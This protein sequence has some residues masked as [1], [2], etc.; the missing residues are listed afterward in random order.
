MEYIQIAGKSEIWIGVSADR[1]SDGSYSTMT[2]VGEQIDDT[3]LAVQ[4]FYHD[5]PGDRHGGPQGPP[6]ERQILGQIVRG[7]FNLSRFDPEVRRELT[8]QNV[9]AT[10]GT[11]LDSEI[12][13]LLLR[14]RS[15]RVVI[16]P[17]RANPIGVGLDGAGDDYYAWNFPCVSINGAIECGQGTKFSALSFQFEAH[18]APDG[19]PNAGVIWNRS[20]ADVVALIAAAAA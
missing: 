16:V 3:R 6:I 1:A 12:G 14:D 19:H 10:E 18:R 4:A 15:Y 20:V 5:V 8:K 13:S 7:M 2:K 11:I 17:G 9:F